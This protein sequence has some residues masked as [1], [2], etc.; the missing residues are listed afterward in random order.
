MN[1]KIFANKIIPLLVSSVVLPIIPIDN[2]RATMA[3]VVVYDPPSNVRYEPNSHSKIICTIK[4]K[5][6]MGIDIDTLN[7][8]WYRV[9]IC[10]GGY[11]HK[12]QIKIIR[13]D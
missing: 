2:A 4:S 11:I 6:K 3:E 8:G 12:S 9:K 5:R 13:I 7:N 1:F 10:G